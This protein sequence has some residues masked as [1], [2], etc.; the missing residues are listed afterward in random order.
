[1]GRVLRS[2][3]VVE[4]FLDSHLAHKLACPDIRQAKLRFAQKLHLIPKESPA[5]WFKPGLRELNNIR[6]AFSHRLDKRVTFA[7][8]PGMMEVLKVARA[9]FT[10]PTPILAIEAF[11]SAAATS[12]SF[13]PKEV[14]DSFGKALRTV[15]GEIGFTFSEEG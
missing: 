14:E 5:Q 3:L 15:L 7:D 8:I 4:S 1:M 13:T 2:H 9:G 12:L 11:S 6:N 10:I